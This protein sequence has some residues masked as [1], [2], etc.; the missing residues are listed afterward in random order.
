MFDLLWSEN[1]LFCRFCR[2]CLWSCRW[3]LGCF[4][5]DTGWHFLGFCFL[6]EGSRRGTRGCNLALGDGWS[7]LRGWNLNGQR[8]ILSL[9]CPHWGS[10][11]LLFGSQSLLG[12]VGFECQNRFVPLL[13]TFW[14]I[15]CFQRFAGWLEDPGRAGSTQ[16][17]FCRGYSCSFWI[18][19]GFLLELKLL[20]RVKVNELLQFWMLHKLPIVLACP[21]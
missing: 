10:D 20:L 4:G 15:W 21:I 1:D 18:R 7:G 3:V 16:A 8:N 12:I 9:C 6:L 5:W 11:G 17:S 13:A 2:C 19:L 14:C